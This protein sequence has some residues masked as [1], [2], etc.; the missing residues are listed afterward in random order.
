VLSYD[1][2]TWAVRRFDPSGHEEAMWRP[3]IPPQKRPFA[4][5]VDSNG[6]YIVLLDDR[7]L[8]YDTAGNPVSQF[9]APGTALFSDV[10]LWSD[11]R[12][13]IATPT[14]DSIL[15]VTRTGEIEREVLRFTGGPGRFR[16]PGSVTVGT[17]GT[18]IVI[19]DDGT[20]LALQS[21]MDQFAPV[22]VRSF[23]INFSSFPVYARG[24]VFDGSGVLL[25]PDPNPIQLVYNPVGERL[26]AADPARDLSSKGFGAVRKF[27]A[28]RDRLYVL[29]EEPRRLW[30]VA[31]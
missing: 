15:L 10:A 23:R 22:F 17:D 16:A 19:Q 14:R 13:L 4:L 7:V 8:M 31:R 27:R 21:P 25:V 28:A 5:V 11:G 2:G 12:M 3:Q 30:V 20:A 29:D 9:Q 1:R 18:V 24:T 26:L 6:T